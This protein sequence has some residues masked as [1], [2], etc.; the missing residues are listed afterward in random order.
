MVVDNQA[1]QQYLN[2]LYR[3]P[4]QTQIGPSNDP[5]FYAKAQQDMLT[6]KHR[7]EQMLLA[8]QQCAEVANISNQM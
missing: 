3:N 4:T 7:I 8:N 6:M 1:M 2:G 5:G